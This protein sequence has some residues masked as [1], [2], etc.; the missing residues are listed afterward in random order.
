MCSDEPIS[1][2]PPKAKITAEV[3]S[4]RRRPKVVHS[5]SRFS[6]GKTICSAITRPTVKPT[7]PQKTAITMKARVTSST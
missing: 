6:A 4:G 5:R 3:C 1:A 2:V 7:T